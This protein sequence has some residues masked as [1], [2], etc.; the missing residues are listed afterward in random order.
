MRL[1]LISNLFS[2]KWRS[3]ENNSTK[4]TDQSEVAQPG[5]VDSKDC[6]LV[7]VAIAGSTHGKNSCSYP[8]FLSDWVRLWHAILR[9]PGG[10]RVRAKLDNLL[11]KVQIIIAHKPVHNEK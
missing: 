6:G 11:P 7:D 2:W 5:F 1:R 9:M 10:G 4:Q 3:E 8:D